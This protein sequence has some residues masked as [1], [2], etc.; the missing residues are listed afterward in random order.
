MLNYQRVLSCQDW[1]ATKTSAKTQLQRNYF[2]IP[3]R[4]AP[5]VIFKYITKSMAHDIATPAERLSGWILRLCRQHRCDKSKP[6][7]GT[8][9]PKQ[10][11]QL[12]IM[13]GSQTPTQ[14]ALQFT[15]TC[16]WHWDATL[17]QHA[18]DVHKRCAKPEGSQWHLWNSRWPRFLGPTAPN[19]SQPLELFCTASA[20]LNRAKRFCN[21]KPQLLHYRPHESHW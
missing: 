1:E 11:I 4:G 19:G 12:T 10:P 18:I 3:A 7:G 5:F 16:A 2:T 9:N 13:R 8:P 20:R 21:S 6:G 17:F 15:W 14:R